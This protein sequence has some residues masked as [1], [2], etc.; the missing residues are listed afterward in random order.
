MSGA[1][2]G[3]HGRPFRGRR[4]FAAAAPLFRFVRRLHRLGRRATA[5][6]T[7]RSRTA[8]ADL[9]G[10]LPAAA[11]PHEAFT[12]A[13]DRLVEVARLTGAADERRRIAA[14]VDHPLAAGRERFACRLATTEGLSFDQAVGAL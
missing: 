5:A 14:V 7:A 13:L 3:A 1:A 2:T 6:A 11:F 9:S 4:V 10:T 12:A 8:A